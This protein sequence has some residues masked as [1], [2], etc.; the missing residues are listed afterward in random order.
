MGGAD[1]V[2][3]YENMPLQYAAILKAVRM[4]NFRLKKI[5]FFL[6]QHLTYPYIVGTQL[7]RFERVH[8]IYIFRAKI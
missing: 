3:H 5:L 4:I 7:R 8:T 2:S 1:R 6:F